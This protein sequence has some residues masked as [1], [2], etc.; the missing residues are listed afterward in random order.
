[1]KGGHDSGARI[2]VET[3]VDHVAAVARALT[4]TTGG[5]AELQREVVRTAASIAGTGASAAI[6]LRAGECLTV[7]VVDEH[8]GI[9]ESFAGWETESEVIAGKRVDRVVDGLGSLLV[10]PMSLD[11]QTVGALAVMVPAAGGAI[12]PDAKGVLAIL[13]NN[14]AVA[15]ENAR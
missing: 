8:V 14:A 13:A 3:A 2:S 12:D 10:L 11:G 15:M 7:R 6:A 4:S 9:G 5:V 1:M